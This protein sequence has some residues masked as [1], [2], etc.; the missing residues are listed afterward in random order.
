M[1]ATYQNIVTLLIK[2]NIDW[3]IDSHM[4]CLTLGSS[5]ILVFLPRYPNFE[6][7]GAVKYQFFVWL[8]NIFI[9]GEEETIYFTLIHSVFL[10]I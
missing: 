9:S 1:S 3:S 4:L 10:F 6:W 8:R 5:L 2:V 7:H